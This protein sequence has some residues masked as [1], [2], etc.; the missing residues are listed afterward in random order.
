MNNFGLGE[1]PFLNLAIAGLA[2]IDNKKNQVN[3]KLPTY[4]PT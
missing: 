3:V 4:L 2:G 1:R